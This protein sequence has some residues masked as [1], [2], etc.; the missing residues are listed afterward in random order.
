MDLLDAR[1]EQAKELEMKTHRAQTMSEEE[2]LELRAE[3]KVRS[4]GKARSR[5]KVQA[6]VTSS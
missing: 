2:I 5:V 6:N 1:E 3:I 4:E